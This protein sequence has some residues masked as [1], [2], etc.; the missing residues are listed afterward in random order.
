MATIADVD[1]L[2]WLGNAIGNSWAPQVY[3]GIPET[4]IVPCDPY[5][6]NVWYDHPEGGART[7]LALYGDISP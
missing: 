6:S 5:R 1:S 2:P 4:L 3:G 7:W